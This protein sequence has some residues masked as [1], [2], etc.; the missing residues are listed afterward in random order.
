MCK[1]LI[2]KGGGVGVETLG[3]LLRRWMLGIIVAQ[4]A[5]CTIAGCQ[6][7]PPKVGIV[8]L[9]ISHAGEGL[10]ECWVAHFPSRQRDQVV[11]GTTRDGSM[12]AFEL[13]NEAV[14]TKGAFVLGGVIAM[15]SGV[16]FERDDPRGLSSVEHAV[17][18][19]SGGEWR[20]SR[21]IELSVHAELLR[22]HD[23][24]G[25]E[26]VGVFPDD[27]SR[28]THL[29]R[30]DGLRWTA[31]SLPASS[32]AANR[33][34]GAS[35]LV[36]LPGAPAVVAGGTGGAILL[37]RGPAAVWRVV[38]GL[39]P[40]VPYAASM[41]QKTRIMFV[42]N[43]SSVTRHVVLGEIV[44]ER[45]VELAVGNVPSSLSAEARVAVAG[46]RAAW[47]TLINEGATTVLTKRNE[48]D[49]IVFQETVHGAEN[50]FVDFAVADDDSYLAITVLRD[51]ASWLVKTR[52]ASGT[53]VEHGIVN[54]TEPQ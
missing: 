10:R 36:T 33:V 43:A 1:L 53:W 6:G 12:P 13:V 3:W 45:F 44:G 46:A 14:E 11:C 16:V 52:Y 20:T 34:G 25:N 18:A 32:S 49:S 17:K 35:A 30:S 28:W 8:Q 50:G 9:S 41:S 26:Y 48:Q 31:E 39:P 27:V 21:L 4:I 42:S 5:G 23:Y 37:H 2:E 7:E 51:D 54:P 38:E 40:G 22:G 19:A 15:P 47:Y 29:I 24:D